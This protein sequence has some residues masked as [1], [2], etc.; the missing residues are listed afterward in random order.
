MT[1]R[2]RAARDDVPTSPSVI[3][4]KQ[5]FSTRATCNTI[6]NAVCM[7]VFV[8]ERVSIIIPVNT[9]SNESKVSHIITIIC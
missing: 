6:D 2:R 7:C 8:C 1:P 4:D 3:M 9:K 5:R